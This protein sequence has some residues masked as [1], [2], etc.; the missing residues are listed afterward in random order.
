MNKFLET[1]NLSRPNEEEPVNMT[2]LMTSKEIKLVTSNLP[3]KVPKHSFTD[4]IYQKFKKKLIVFK[5]FQKVEEKE[6]VPTILEEVSIILIT[7]L[8]IPQ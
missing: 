5:I 3:T 2:R 1:Y 6:T 4:E 8:K 7:K